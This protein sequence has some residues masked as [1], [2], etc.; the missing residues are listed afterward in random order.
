MEYQST[1]SSTENENEKKTLKDRTRGRKRKRKTKKGLKRERRGCTGKGDQ[2]AAI[3]G[4]ATE[5]FFTWRTTKIAGNTDEKKARNIMGD[6]KS[7][8]QKGGAAFS[9]KKREG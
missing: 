4:E 3:G 1:W 5:K 8:A 6:Q 7:I 9:R 2:V